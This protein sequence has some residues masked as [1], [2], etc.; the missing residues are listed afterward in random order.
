LADFRWAAADSLAS[1]GTIGDRRR[2]RS[3]PIASAISRSLVA[4]QRDFRIVGADAR[5][6]GMNDRIIVPPH[7]ITARH[8]SIRARIVR[9]PRPI[10]PRKRRL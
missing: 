1:G 3:K 8:R 7:A 2:R 5:S 9:V 4:S 10:T 6:G